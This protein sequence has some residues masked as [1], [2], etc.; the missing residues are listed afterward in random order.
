MRRPVGDRL[1]AYATVRRRG[2]TASIGIDRRVRPFLGSLLR[3][4][5]DTPTRR[6]VPLSPFIFCSLPSARAYKLE[7]VHRR[8]IGSLDKSVP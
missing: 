2:D 7:S 5:A 1:E 4:H 8:L 3:R 6:Y